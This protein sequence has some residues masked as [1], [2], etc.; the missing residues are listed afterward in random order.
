MNIFSTSCHLYE[1]V[2]NKQISF[3]LVNNSYIHLHSK[4]HTNTANGRE[5][6]GFKRKT[7]CQLAQLELQI[8]G[9][10]KYLFPNFQFRV[11]VNEQQNY[12]HADISFN[13][14][15]IPHGTNIQ[16]SFALIGVNKHEDN[17]FI[18]MNEWCFRPRFSTV[19]LNWARDTLGE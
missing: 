8:Q 11:G 9:P 15:H 18:V 4:F 5:T 17:Q 19:R 6:R 2:E 14:P 10:I 13:R 3:V 7:I 16:M 1:K 12:I